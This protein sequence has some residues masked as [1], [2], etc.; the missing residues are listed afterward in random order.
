MTVNDL[1]LWLLTRSFFDSEGLVRQHLD[2]YNDFIEQDLQSIID[3]V[4]E[5]T[6]DSPDY[7]FRIRLKHIEIGRPRVVEVDGSDHPVYPM[8][9]RLRNLSYAAPLYLEMAVVRDER[10][11]SSELVHIGD[12]PVMLKS[13]LCLL[14][15]NS[16]SE[17]IQV[18]EDPRDPGG[19]FI[20]NGSEREIVAWRTS[21]PTEYRSTETTQ[22]PD[23][24]SGQ[25]SSR[26]RLASEPA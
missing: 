9:C 6:I 5:I 16:P 25:K 8:E 7:P 1:D 4:G 20:V 3:E 18:G 21:L 17:L 13:K 15:N 26:Q 22:V 10:E 11:E 23:Q 24:C 14:Y 2:S 19:Y 12:I